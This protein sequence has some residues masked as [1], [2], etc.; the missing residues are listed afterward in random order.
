MKNSHLLAAFFIAASI[1]P[2]AAQSDA[3][4]AR[5]TEFHLG[6]LNRTPGESRIVTKSGPAV[7]ENVF[8]FLSRDHS[9]LKPV[10]PASAPWTLTYMGAI[11][12]SSDQGRTWKKISSF[13]R[14]AQ[15]A[16]QIA[17]MK[18][19]TQAARDLECDEQ[20]MGGATYDVYEVKLPMIGQPGI[21]TQNV[22]MVD[23]ATRIAVQSVTQFKSGG[24]ET[25]TTQHWKLAPNLTLPKPE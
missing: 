3:C 12:Q 20:K 15:H 13:D 6:S 8:L 22:Y 2:A 25:I 17:S 16:Q 14:E 23:R 11:Y 5:F 24:L 10:K 21:E 4:R 19:Q 18:Q 9:L 1:V 7:T